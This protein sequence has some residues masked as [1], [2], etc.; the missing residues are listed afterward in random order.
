MIVD[1][2]LPIMD[3]MGTIPGHPKVK[4]EPL[5]RHEVHGRTNTL[6]SM[7]LHNAGTHIDAPYHFDKNGRTID[8]VPLT[9]LIGPAE[10]VDLREDL[11]EKREIE[12]EDIQSK[13]PPR[14]AGRILVLFTGWCD[15]GYFTP[16]YYVK[17]PFISARTAE[18][19]VERRIKALAGDT[20][21]DDVESDFPVH[22]TLLK[23]G[24]PHIENVINLERLVGKDFELYAIPIKIH[25]GDGAPA[26]VFAFTK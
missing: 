23:N 15:K 3:G 25:E 12:I 17:N 13:V 8:L 10:L 9:E 6:L 24:I 11:R 7:S 26:R 1:L 22:R 21:F 5:H 14:I 20:P 2:T 16:E 19:L 4:M 18:W